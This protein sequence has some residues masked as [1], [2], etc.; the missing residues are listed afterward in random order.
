ML[1]TIAENLPI[2]LTNGPSLYRGIAVGANAIY[3]SS[4]I[5][6]T[7]YRLSRD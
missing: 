3:L 4:D 7:I 2:G 6:N 1:R 5:D